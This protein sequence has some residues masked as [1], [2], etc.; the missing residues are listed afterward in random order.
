MEALLDAMRT[1]G[2][3]LPYARLQRDLACALLREARA[4]SDDGADWDA[5]LEEVAALPLDH[6]GPRE[7]REVRKKGEDFDATVLQRPRC[8]WRLLE[9]VSALVE[10][11]T[12]PGDEALDLLDNLAEAARAAFFCFRESA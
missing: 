4:L 7:L 3:A 6:V 8:V 10:A 2:M 11:L 12:P 9:A 1:E 5:L